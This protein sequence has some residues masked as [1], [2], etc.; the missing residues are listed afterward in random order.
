M[1]V[2]EKMVKEVF[3][4]SVPCPSNK[5]LWMYIRHEKTPTKGVIEQVLFSATPTG[6]VVIRLNFHI[7]GGEVIHLYSYNFHGHL[8]IYGTEEDAINHVRTDKDGSYYL[9]KK[10]I[11]TKMEESAKYYPNASYVGIILK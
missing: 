3:S 1:K 10:E 11:K 2:T 8:T 4:R 6:I 9:T 5:S 7:D